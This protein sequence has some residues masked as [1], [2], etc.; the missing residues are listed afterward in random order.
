MKALSRHELSNVTGGFGALLGA[1]LQ[2]APGILQGVGGIIGAAKS[3]G[4]GG[5]GG[6]G[7]APAQ[8]AAAPAPA[9]APAPMPA[10]MPTSAGG[11]GD[12]SPKIFNN[13]QIS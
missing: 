6:G 5:G 10:A 3:G 12:W 2:A 9:P 1:A 8:A 11:G 13:V 7:G 4:G